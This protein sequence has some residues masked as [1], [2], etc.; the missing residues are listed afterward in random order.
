MTAERRKSKRMPMNVR[1]KL[2][3]LK[4]GIVDKDVNH[5][6][7]EVEVVNISKDGIA[8]RSTEKLM[9]NT[10]YDANIMLWTKESFQ[11]VMEIV[12]MENRGDEPPLYGCRFVGILPA[13]QLKIQIY[14]MVQDGKGN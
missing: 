9:M 12:R 5:S 13:D 3:E 2:N 6:E 8:F 11:A 1:I 10:F 7:F 4:S 14:D